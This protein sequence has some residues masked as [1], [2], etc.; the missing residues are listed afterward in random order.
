MNNQSGFQDAFLAHTSY[1]PYIHCNDLEG[2]IYTD[3]YERE[4]FISVRRNHLLGTQC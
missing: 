3:S 2:I 1:S 4:A